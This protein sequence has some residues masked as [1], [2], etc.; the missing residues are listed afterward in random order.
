M[1][2][3]TLLTYFCPFVYVC[4]SL[5]KQAVHQQ[6]LIYAGQ[7]MSGLVRRRLKL[8]VGVKAPNVIW[9]NV[10]GNYFFV[11]LQI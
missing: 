6:E 4:H 9:N 2:M 1:I 3:S 8:S 5:L 11:D 10:D 7:R